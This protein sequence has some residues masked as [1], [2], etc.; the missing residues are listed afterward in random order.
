MR[1]LSPLLAIVA[2]A[3]LAIPAM[4]APS[5]LQVFGT[6]DATVTGTASATLVNGPGEYSGV[7]LQSKSQSGKPIGNVS[8]SFDHA[9]DIAGG[10]PRFSIPVDTDG[11]GSVEGYAFLDVNGCGNTGTVSTTSSTCQVFFGGEA[12]ANW[13]AFAA[14]HPTY[15]IAPGSIPFIIA[16][17]EGSY[18]ITSID[19]R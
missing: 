8:F 18:T 14:A 16:D 1:R 3:T 9:G 6:G 4:A 11:N 17:Q 13:A 15:R 7:Y 12:F 10:A 19:L 2:I 5:K